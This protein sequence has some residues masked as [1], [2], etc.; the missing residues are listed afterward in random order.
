MTR[1]LFG[2]FVL[3]TR[4]GELLRDGQ[5]VPLRPKCYDLLVYL[6]QQSGVLLSKERLLRDVW[7]DVLVEEAT[8]SKTVAELRDALG[9]EGPRPSIIQTVRSR[10]YRFA[11]PVQAE[12][13]P[14]ATASSADLRFLHGTIDHPLSDGE[15]LIGRDEHVG[16]VLHTPLASRHH[17]R[18]RVDGT[19]VIIEDTGSKNGTFVN[20]ERID[21][22]RVLKLGD[23]IDIGGET[24]VLWSPATAT[25]AAR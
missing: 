22:A 23:K 25:T 8:L 12:Q 6:T 18:V 11:L 14:T 10:G 21:S 1:H 2:R 9:D 24:L 17:A 13:S 7:R 5:R 4:S 20:G 3:D 19:L 16:I 15:H